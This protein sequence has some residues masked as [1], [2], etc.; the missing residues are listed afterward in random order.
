M[1]RWLIGICALLAVFGWMV[2][3]GIV[4]LAV[5]VAK[6]VA[7][8]AFGIAAILLVIGVITYSKVKGMLS[9]QPH[10]RT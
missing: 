3:S 1:H 2:L 7:Y 8:G 6:I 10:P 5:E 4:H 9:D